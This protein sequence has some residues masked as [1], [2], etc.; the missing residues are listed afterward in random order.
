MALPRATRILDAGNSYS[1]PRAPLY[2]SYSMETSYAYPE[3]R[4]LR[5][6][7]VMA[8]AFVLR[9]QMDREHPCQ[10][11][12]GVRRW[13]SALIRRFWGPSSL[14]PVP[15]WAVGK[16]RKD[17]DSATLRTVVIAKRDPD[18]HEDLIRWG[19]GGGGLEFGGAHTPPPAMDEAHPSLRMG[20]VCHA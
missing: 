6:P 1:I 8:R 15:C 16:C 5:V 4:Q 11:R 18:R 9:Q 17:G 3:C 12:A 10:R 19:A 14:L 7:T 20:Y 13:G 2:Y